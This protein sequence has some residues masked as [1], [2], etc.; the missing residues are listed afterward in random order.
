MYAKIAYQ[1]IDTY[2]TTTIALCLTV[3]NTYK[4]DSV[5]RTGTVSTAGLPVT[6]PP[7]SSGSQFTG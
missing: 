2:L 6:H 5:V 3:V 1:T 4:C 7:G